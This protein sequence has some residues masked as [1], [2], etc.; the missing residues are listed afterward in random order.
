MT[1]PAPRQPSHLVVG[2]LNK[3]H[4]TGGELFVWSLTDRPESTFV[5]GVRFELAQ[6]TRQEPDPELPGLTIESVRPY[7]RG[8]LVKFEHVD[9]RTQAELFR[10]RYLLRP[11]E[12]AEPLAEGEVFYHQLLGLRVTTAEGRDLGEVSEVYELQPADLLEVRGPEGTRLIPFTPQVV[13]ELDLEEGRIVVDPPEGLL[14][15]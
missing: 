14:E 15:L 1:D 9:D 10:G 13:A 5:A 8:Y 4:G 7:K 12:E 2:H 3:A 6:A 11:F